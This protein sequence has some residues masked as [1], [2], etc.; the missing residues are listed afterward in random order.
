MPKVS[1]SIH[2]S[3]TKLMKFDNDKERFTIQLTA[4][5]ERAAALATEIAALVAIVGEVKTDFRSPRSRGR[6]RTP[7]LPS[8]RSGP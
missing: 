2:A 1:E 6:S 5:E 3:E 7:N 4:L 8:T